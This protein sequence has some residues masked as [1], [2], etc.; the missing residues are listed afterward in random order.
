[1]SG[2]VAHFVDFMLGA[3]TLGTRAAPGAYLLFSPCAVGL[4]R[5]RELGLL[6]GV[7]GFALL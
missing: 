3:E 4:K 7:L 1:M 2:G 6:V 5:L